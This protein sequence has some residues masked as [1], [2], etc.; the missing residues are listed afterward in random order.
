MLIAVRKRRLLEY[1]IQI[2]WVWSP[3]GAIKVISSNF[4]Q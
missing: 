1:D 2:K 4:L 3:F